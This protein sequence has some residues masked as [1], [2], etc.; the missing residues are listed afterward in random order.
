MKTP[1]LIFS[2]LALAGTAHADL[3]WAYQTVDADRPPNHYAEDAVRTVPGSSLSLTQGELDDLY[4]PPDWFPQDHAPMPDIVAHGKPG[5]DAR[6]C[7]SCH[8]ASGMG[9][10]E[11]SQVAGLPVNYFMRQMADFA[12]GARKDVAWMNRIA[13]H[14]TE[15]ESRA[16]AEYFAALE[17]IDYISEVIETDMVPNNYNGEGR[18]RFLHP[19]GGTRPLPKNELVEVPQNIELVTARHPYSGFMVY[20]PTGS[21]A[22]GE[23]LAR[24]GGNGRTLQCTICHGQDLGG[25]GDVPRIAGLSP[26]YAVRQ[27]NDF[28]TG[29]R[30]GPSAALMQATVVNL[31]EE[32]IV[33][34]AAYLATLDP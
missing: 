34:L 3:Q 10:P 29:A 18:M 6:A 9:H 2:T 26:V 4:N 5:T 22:R 16:A 17:P 14:V 33:A 23:E 15:E 25:L 1:W 32:D 12:S 30:G 19:D 27:L 7:A 11:S 8:L 20:A 31:T 13:P 21:V 28:K 24:T